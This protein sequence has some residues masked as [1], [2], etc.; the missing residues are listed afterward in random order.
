MSIP[1]LAGGLP[2]LGHALEFWKNP[3]DLLRRGRDLHGELFSFRL[4]GKTVHVLTEPGGNEAFFRAPDDQLS[5]RE[6][7]RFTIPMFGKGVAYDV[8]PELMDEQIGLIIPALRDA[9]MQTYVQAM[10]EEA[11]AYSDAWGE[12]GE[13]ELTRAMNEMTV[14]NACRCLIGREFRRRL[15]AEFAASYHDLE[16][17]VNLIAF[18]RPGWPL[19][20]MRRRDRGRANILRLISQVLQERRRR[21]GD[22]DFVDTLIAARYADGGGLTDHEI[23]G[24]LLTLIFA[25][26]HT[27]AI[28]ASWTGIL[29]LRHQRYL[30]RVRIEQSRLD[31]DRPL[32]LA[33]LRSLV[34]LER[35]I[36]EAERMYPPLVMLM[37]VILRDFTYRGETLPAGD[38][39]MVA[40]AVT[41]RLAHVFREPNRYDPDRFGPG[42]EEDRRT[43]FALIGF[44][45]GKHRCI[46]A[47]F[48][49]QHIKVLWTVLLRK[50]H[51]ELAPGD[52]PPDYSTFVV[53]PRQPC[54]IRYRRRSVRAPLAVAGK[55]THSL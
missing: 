25:G 1:R 55:E 16:A 14:F 43:Q 12:E 20:A 4:V 24:L 19:P 46:G 18:F 44:G 26:Q 35:C 3:V 10:E 8:S 51:L 13:F 15:S 34:M 5:A 11:E 52:Y 36:K 28:M 27:T 23:T 50:F 39:A 33:A 48:A 40:P 6:A 21:P 31:R 53:G 37:R 38:L 42:R 17:G 49:Y 41:H 54:I 29:L 7:Y 47:G 32:T 30:E 45:G 9:R 22:E 2:L